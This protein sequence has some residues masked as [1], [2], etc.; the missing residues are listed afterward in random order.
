[1]F[2]KYIKV[3]KKFGVLFLVL[4]I[5][6]SACSTDFDVIGDWKETIVVYGLLDQSQ[7]KQYIKINKAFLGEG[8]AFEYAQIKD[9]AQFVNSMSVT[10]KKI[11]NGNEIASYNL[12]PDN[13]IPKNSGTF[14]GP[15]QGNAIYSFNSTGGNTLTQD[16][17]YKLIIRNNETGSE[18]TSQTSLVNDFGPLLSPAS[19]AQYAYIAS[20][21]NPNYRFSLRFVTAAYARLYQ[22]IIRLHYTDST[23]AGNVAKTLDWKLGQKTTEKLDGGE[24]LDFGFK[25]EDYMK[26]IGSSLSDYSGL[27]NRKAGNVEIIVVSAADE[28]STYIDVNKPSTGIIQEKPEY[29]NITNGLGLLSARLYKTSF[30]KPLSGETKD[31]LSGGDYTHCLKFLGNSGVWL[32]AGS[33]LPCN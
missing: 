6:F 7:S 14:Y 31:E 20:T 26:F 2:K 15:D 3:K 21:T 11:R 17:Q 29:T 19:G 33:P 24:E 32:G 4:S 9:S 23:S 1:L 5:L 18:V 27:Y 8:N 22:V 25:G 12:T 28:L 16:S 13:T 30:D 10:L